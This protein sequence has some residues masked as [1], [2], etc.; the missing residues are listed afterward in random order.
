MIDRLCLQQDEPVWFDRDD[1]PVHRRLRGSSFSKTL[2][3]SDT[4]THGGFSIP[5]RHADDCFPPLVGTS[6]LH[7]R[8]TWNTYLAVNSRKFRE[9]FIQLVLISC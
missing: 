5:K 9:K 4:S 2:T 6:F 8:T 7:Y 1:L 3:A